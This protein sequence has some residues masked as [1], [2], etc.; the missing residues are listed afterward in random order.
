MVVCRQCWI[1]VQKKFVTWD[2]NLFFFLNIQF[3]K[4][5]EK[6]FV[7]TWIF[8]IFVIDPIDAFGEHWVRSKYVVDGDTI[9]L[10]NG[11]LVRYIGIDAPEIDHKTNSAEPYGFISREFNKNMVQY[12]KLRL[13]Y[14][15][16]PYDHHGRRLAYVFLENGLF[17][18]QA[19]IE[20]G[21]AIYYFHKN[22]L[23]YQ[24]ILLKKQQEAMTGKKGMWKNWREKSSRYLGNSN[25]KRF[26]VPECSSGAKTVSRNKVLFKT[27]WEAFWNGYS[28]CRQCL[29]MGDLTSDDP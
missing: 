27:S 4:N 5:I 20:N 17:V 21:Y 9:V 15:Q 28:P 12:G 29:R 3:F 18:N 7:L 2:S 10:E 1:E 13:E 22:N 26:H 8:L 25:S 19:L 24:E 16:Q 11:D 14:D 6:F 23:K